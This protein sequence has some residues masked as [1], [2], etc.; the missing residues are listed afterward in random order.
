VKIW[1]QAGGLDLKQEK[2]CIKCCNPSALTPLNGY[3]PQKHGST[4]EFML[5][6]FKAASKLD[7][8]KLCELRDCVD[9][10]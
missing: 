10:S 9:K 3:N 8:R 6:P 4:L 1:P 5:L 2:N 7:Q